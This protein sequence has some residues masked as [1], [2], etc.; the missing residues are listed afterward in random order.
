MNILSCIYISFIIGFSYNLMSYAFVVPDFYCYNEYG[1]LYKKDWADTK[2]C[3]Y[4]Y[5]LKVERSSLISIYGYYGD[6]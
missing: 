6:K 5:T 1:E 3:K 2:N 4:G